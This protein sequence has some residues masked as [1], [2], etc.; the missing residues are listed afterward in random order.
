MANKTTQIGQNVH[1]TETDE[2]LTFTVS[3]KANP[4]VSS[5]GRSDVLATTSG[6][7]VI[8][9]CEGWTLGFNLYS[10]SPREG[11][12]PAPKG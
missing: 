8:P 10:T 2:T 12:V 5:T 6:N 7:K 11:Y 3:K 4:T 1:V 9:G